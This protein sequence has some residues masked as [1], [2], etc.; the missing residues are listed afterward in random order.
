MP[1]ERR[2]TDYSAKSAYQSYEAAKEYEG[3]PVYSGIAG[4]Y[5]G[6]L[7]N[8]SINRLLGEIPRGSTFLDCPCGNGRWL[9]SLARRASRI[10]A[11]DVSEG[12]VRFTTQRAATMVLDIEVCQGDAE[13][14]QLDDGA[15]DYAFSFALTKHLPVPVQYRVLA[16]FARVSR[17]GVLCSFS[18]LKH[19]SYAAWRGRNLSESYPVFIE[20][21]GW[22]AEAAGLVI[23]RTARCSSPVGLEHVVLFDKVP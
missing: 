6:W 10:T 17:R 1:D 11:I 4:R 16:E 9:E 15:V 22:M 7:E 20:E 13:Q 19:L 23:R 21:V 5:R 12:M 2:A 14:L 18:V 3:R 8:R